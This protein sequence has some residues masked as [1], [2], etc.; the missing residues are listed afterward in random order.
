MR[1]NHML[2]ATRLAGVAAMFSLASCSRLAGIP[3]P[4]P[5]NTPADYLAARPYLELSVGGAEFILTEPSSSV[6]ILVL[7]LLTIGLGAHFLRTRAGQR[8]RFWWGLSF[9]AWG[10]GALLAGTSYQAFAYEIKS[11]GRAVSSWTSWWEIFYMLFTV[12]SIGA[13]TMGVAHACANGR[14]R[15]ALTVYAVVDVALYFAVCLTGA[16]LP[17]K[18]LVS[19]EL[20]VLFTWPGYVAFFVINVRRYIKSRTKLDRSLMVTWVSLFIVMGGYY[21]Y[22][23][24]GLG[25]ALWARGLWFNANDFLHVGLIGWMLYIRLKVSRELRDTGE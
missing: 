13:M 19:F 8:S 17:N 2:R 5:G 15:K 18:F 25:E 12:A 6:F 20:M 9:V 7:G 4:S 21:V 10:I 22:L 11:A 16:F 1:K 3:A 24:S 14:L 23:L